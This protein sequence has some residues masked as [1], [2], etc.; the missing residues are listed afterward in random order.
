MLTTKGHVCLIADE[1]CLIITLHLQYTCGPF[2][3]QNRVL[4]EERR[5]WSIE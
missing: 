3:K 4:D 2:E 1:L 5:R